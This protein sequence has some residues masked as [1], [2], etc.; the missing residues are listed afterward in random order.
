MEIEA[1]QAL[2]SPSPEDHAATVEAMLAPHIATSSL[3]AP[4]AAATAAPSSAPAPLFDV[5]KLD[6]SLDDLFGLGSDDV[7]PVAARTAPAPAAAAPL[8]D[9][10]KLDS[11]LDDL[12]GLSDE[13]PAAAPAPVAVEPAKSKLFDVSTLD[14][15]L[16]DLFGLSDAPAAKAPEPTPEPVRPA[17]APVEAAA[18]GK[19]FDPSL[20]LSSFDLSSFSLDKAMLQT[21]PLPGSTA[22]PAAASLMSQFTPAA[23]TLP[24]VSEVSALPT[25]SQLAEAAPAPRPEPPKQQDGL[26]SIGKLLVD[27][28]TLEEIIRTA[29]KGGKGGLTTTQVISAVKGKSLD[30]VLEGINTS[31]GVLGSLIVGR[32]GLVITNT[33]PRDIDKDLVGAL[34][35]SLFANTDIQI[36]RMQRGLLKRLIL[37]TDTGL[38]VLAQLEMGTL[39]V[40]TKSMEE[41]DLNAI[42][43]AVTKM[44]GTN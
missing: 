24:P 20:T 29:E 1:A 33:M 32:D 14:S 40:F 13:A 7:P 18:A 44:A 22:A 37:E 38:S 23:S 28:N 41:T 16:D 17:A 34:T 15:S 26:I 12:F 31:K 3:S 6:S 4:A 5:D 21:T 25:V 8:F 9:V 27:Q 36:K 42:M 43:A 30:S 10:D 11:S 39:V 35:S 19:A 2:A